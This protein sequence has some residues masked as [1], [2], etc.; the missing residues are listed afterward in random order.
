MTD[1]ENHIVFTGILHS[2]TIYA[3]Q[4]FVK[5][6]IR[7]PCPPHTPAGIKLPTACFHF[8]LVF[9]LYPPGKEIAP[10]WAFLDDRKALANATLALS[11][12]CTAVIEGMPN[13]KQL[14]EEKFGFAHGFQGH[15][16]D[17]TPEQKN[18]TAFS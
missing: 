4:Y 11:F 12:S 1:T 7:A 5:G 9:E 10:L 17:Y 2:K 6:E 3:F 18:M 14:R 16:C 15:V 13:R 8:H